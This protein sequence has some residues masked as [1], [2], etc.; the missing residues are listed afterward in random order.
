MAS[1]YLDWPCQYLYNVLSFF[2]LFSKYSRR[3]ENHYLKCITREAPLTVL[4]S[5]PPAA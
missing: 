1:G 5:R 2:Q 4:Q 3:V